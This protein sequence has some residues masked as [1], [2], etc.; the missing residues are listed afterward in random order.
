MSIRTTLAEVSEIIEVDSD[1]GIDGF[2]ETASVLVDRVELRITAND[3]LILVGL[4][5]EEDEVA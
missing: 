3:L 1:L 4:V 5:R 2:I